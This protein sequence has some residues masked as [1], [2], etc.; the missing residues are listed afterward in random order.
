MSSDLVVWIVDD[1]E[2]VRKSIAAVLQTY[3]ICVRDYESA[4]AFLEDFQPDVT[5]FLIADHHMPDMTGLELLQHLRSNAI[6][7]PAVVITGQGDVALEHKFKAVGA[8]AMLH[9]P[10]DGDELMTL[11][12]SHFPNK[13]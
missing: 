12:K 10:V 4:R 8:I 7:I 9:K 3:G 11:V 13:L 5:G 1:A 2:S 6:T